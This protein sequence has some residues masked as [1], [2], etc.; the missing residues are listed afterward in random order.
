M[1][2]SAGQ[3]LRCVGLVFEEHSLC[4]LGI[5]FFFLRKEFRYRGEASQKQLWTGKELCRYS[6]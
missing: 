5:A 2:V 4:S 1:A 6:Q 3:A